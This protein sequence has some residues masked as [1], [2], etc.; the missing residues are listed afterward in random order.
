MSLLLGYNYASD[1]TLYMFKSLKDLVIY[2]YMQTSTQLKARIDDFFRSTPQTTTN[3]REWTDIESVESVVIL[4][5]ETN[6]NSCFEARQTSE[7]DKEDN[8]KEEKIPK[9]NDGHDCGIAIFKRIDKPS[10]WLDLQSRRSANS[11]S[12]TLDSCK[13]I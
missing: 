10:F 2:M 4:S 11:S 7:G 3:L 12:L 13:V 6:G 5:L 8:G 1:K 9:L